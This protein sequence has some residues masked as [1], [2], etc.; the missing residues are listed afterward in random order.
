MSKKIKS[1]DLSKLQEEDLLNIKIC[2]LPIKLEGTWVEECVQQLYRELKEKGIHFKPPCYLAD[3]WLTPDQE[4]VIG[5]PFYLAHP[6]LIKLEKKMMLEAEGETKEECMKLLRHET[7]HAINYAHKLYR[8]KKWQRVFGRFL[9]DYPDTYKFRPYSKSFVRHLRG[10][11][12]QYH[13]D[14]DFTE[15]FAVWLTPN[16]DWANAYKGWRALVKL[17]YVDELMNGIKDKKPLVP[18]GKKYWQVATLRMTLRSY[19]KKKRRFHAEDF[20]GFHDPYLKNIFKPRNEDN[21]KLPQ[22]VKILRKYKK[23]IL[24]NISACTGEKKYVVDDVYKTILKRCKELNLVS[25]GEETIVALK[26]TTYLTMMI[27]NYIYTG[28]LRRKI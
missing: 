27:M 15:T 9:T 8:R 28:W 25:P 13:P 19:Y 3:E 23:E 24:N 20:P 6:A 5:I 1:E 10:H 26:M 16:L 21:K 18:K 2:D 22:A 7:G 4:P 14:E 12:A 11:Y 17:R